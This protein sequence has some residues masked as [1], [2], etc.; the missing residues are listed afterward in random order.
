MIKNSRIHERIYQQLKKHSGKIVDYSVVKEWVLRV[1][2]KKGG[3]PREDVP[4]IIDELVEDKKLK[5]ICRLKYEILP[6]EKN[7]REP[8]F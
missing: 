6:S 1:V 3:L 7:I 8:I 5:K 2:Y 4:K